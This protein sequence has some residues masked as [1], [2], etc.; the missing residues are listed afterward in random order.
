MNE[1]AVEAG[2]KV[3]GEGTPR[4][5]FTT[6]P[7]PAPLGSGSCSTPHP[8]PGAPCAHLCA[9]RT[10]QAAAPRLFAFALLSSATPCPL[11]QSPG[12]V[13]PTPMQTKHRDL[14]SLSLPGLSKSHC[15]G[16]QVRP[17]RA[18]ARLQWPVGGHGL[19]S[20]PLEGSSW[21]WPLPGAGVGG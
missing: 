6:P 18:Q 16:Q 9:S 19:G 8:K 15:C 17:Q 10:T 12:P 13:H 3:R 7:R 21:D 5:S 2:L 20:T 4:R 1:G 11:G 14:A